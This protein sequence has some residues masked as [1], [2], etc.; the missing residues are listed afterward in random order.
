MIFD[1]LE[2]RTLLSSSLAGGVLTVTGTGNN[3]NFALTLVS[4]KIVVNEHVGVNKSYLASAVTI[5]KANMGVGKDILTID[6]AITKPTSLVGGIGDD[7]IKG[8]GGK[9]SIFGSGGNDTLLGSGGDDQLNGEDNDDHLIGGAGK[10]AMFGGNGNDDMDGGIGN[11]FF[12]GGTGSD[13]ADYSSRSTAVSAVLDTNFAK[14]PM[15]TAGSGGGAGEKDTYIGIETLRGGSGKDALSYNAASAPVNKNVNYPI[16]LDGGAGND[17]IF[18]GG[19]DG[20]GA[21]TAFKWTIVTENGGAGNDDLEF[22][23]AVS[24]KIFGGGDNDSISPTGDA[25]GRGEVTL[26]IT[27]DGGSGTDTYDLETFGTPSFTYTIPPTIERLLGEDNDGTVGDVTING[28][29]QANYIQW[30][31]GHKVTIF[32]KG[33]DD[34]IVIQE[35]SDG[36]APATSEVHGGDGKDTIN[37][38][39]N[40]GSFGKNTLL[41]EGGNDSIHGGMGDDSLIG[42]PGNDQLFGG[43]GNDTLIGNDGQ[44][45]TLNGGAGTDTA[46]KDPIDIVTSIEIFI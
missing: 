7:S 10:D 13:T 15:Q 2:A 12:S 30:G 36:V 21:P 26:P 8:G 20:P 19:P 11:D 34:K 17:Q 46:K 40:G 38:L 39:F 14:A 9:D 35:N 28:N 29:D 41:G 5:I 4:G 22:N 32:A 1:S 24:T 27:V 31:G 23:G 45:D 33:G 37:V 3:D 42:G 43:M 44:K 16:L 6:D 25:V 18:A